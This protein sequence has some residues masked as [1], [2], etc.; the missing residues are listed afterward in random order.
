[1]S[2]LMAGGYLR[3]SVRAY[4]PHLKRRPSAPSY[5]SSMSTVNPILGYLRYAVAHAAFPGR[6][7]LFKSHKDT[8]RGDTMFGS[9][10]LVLPTPH[11]GGSLVLKHDNSQYT[12]EATRHLFPPPTTPRLA[13]VAF[14][15]DVDHE[16]ESVKSGHRITVTYN[17][18]FVDVHDRNSGL[19]RGLDIIQPRGANHPEVNSLLETLLGDPTFLPE[20][21]TLGFGLRHLYPLP[22]T[23]RS[24]DDDT[25]EVLK[26]RLKGADAALS[27][28]CK[29]LSLV[30][31]LHTVFEHTKGN[32]RVL[33]ACPRVVKISTH[34]HDHDEE[35]WRKLCRRF[36][37]FLVNPSQAFIESLP[38][39]DEGHIRSTRVHWITPLLQENQVKTRF[40]AYGNEPM[41]GYLYQR[42]CLLVEVG[43]FGQAPRGLSH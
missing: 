40:A 34:D 24:H 6:D 5:I 21:G 19:S 1:M 12:F 11:E 20:G 39:P 7:S 23:F 15:S 17:L 26:G 38:P 10:V 37:G 31:I 8:P 27:D 29:A 43:P 36:D 30:P 32:S 18:H 16:V 14:F 33:V 41:M 42:I 2:T 25:L 22:T 28:A 3:R 13:F 9:L 4:S 35:V